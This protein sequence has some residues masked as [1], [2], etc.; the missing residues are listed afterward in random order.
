[1]RA[2][3]LAL[4]ACTAAA[5]HPAH[6]D[7]AC[8]AVRGCPPAAPV[9]PCTVSYAEVDLADA[10]DGADVALRGT[11][12]HGELVCTLL[13]CPDH[14]CNSCGGNERLHTGGRLVKLDRGLT[15]DDSALCFSV[16]HDEEPVVI[17]GT[18]TRA[19]DASVSLAITSLCDPS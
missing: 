6:R 11:L 5:H 19:R 16:G 15:G 9:A 7:A 4:A 13:L 14:C 8:L 1:M 10:P 2:A 12:G 18:L 17:T 3:L